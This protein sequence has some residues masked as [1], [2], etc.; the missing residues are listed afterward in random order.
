[1]PADPKPVSGSF[2]DLYEA[3]QTRPSVKTPA[4]SEPSPMPIP[5]NRGTTEPRI[6]ASAEPK[7][8]GTAE[9]RT[10]TG[11]PPTPQPAKPGEFA[12]AEKPY[13]PHG[14]LWTKAELWALDDIKKEFARQYDVETSLQEL[15]RCALH[16]FVEDYRSRGEQSFAVKRVVKKKR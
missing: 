3:M 15:I 4:T 10:G 14:F 5:R 12:L 11:T 16:M 9:P 6:R 1:M 2:S 8:R 13:K 7:I